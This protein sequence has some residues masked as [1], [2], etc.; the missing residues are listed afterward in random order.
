MKPLLLLLI[1]LSCFTTI[2]S[3]PGVA[4]Q[5]DV[6]GVPVCASFWEANAVFVGQLRDI[7]PPDSNSPKDEPSV[8]TLH[9][10]VEQPF[11]GVN[12]A[13]VDVNTM[14][15]TMCDT[16]FV[17]G[18]RYLVYAYGDSKLYTG[19]C[20]RTTRFENA[21]DDLAYIRS[22]MQK[23]AG[24]SIAGKVAR[25]KYEAVP[26]TKIQIRSETKTIEAIA[27]EEGDFSIS[28]PGPGKYAVTVQVPG[29]FLAQ[30]S[31]PDAHLKVQT[32][33]MLTTIEYKI[34]LEK[35]QCDYRQF[36]L[37]RV[38]LHATAEISGAVLTRSGQPI[39]KGQVY[40]ISTEDSNRSDFTKIEGDGSFKFKDIAAGEYFLALNPDNLAPG[41]DDAPHARTYYPSASDV[42]GATKIAVTEG[43][44]LESLTLRVGPALKAKLVSGRVVWIDGST[45]INVHLSLYNGDRYVQLID[46]DPKGNFNFKTY[47]DFKYSLEARVFGERRGQSEK[48]PITE[49][50]TNLK[51][52]LAQ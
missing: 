50:S 29:S 47:G 44:K 19:F 23:S 9:F 28:L 35:S 13:T 36:D 46:V 30:P 52:V 2:S 34:E 41:K 22:I 17:E 31:T 42:A 5:C 8:V 10:I 1:A 20:T 40:L 12:G 33:D 24:E 21:T 51:I 3:K 39:N 7:T 26:G 27:D 37:F 6:Y 48:V 45:A 49:K 25:N 15:G 14:S 4:C 38:D 32:T 11:R 18:Q 43:A 16:K